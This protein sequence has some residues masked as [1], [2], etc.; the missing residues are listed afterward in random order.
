VA[1]AT[2]QKTNTVFIPPGE[3]KQVFAPAPLAWVIENLEL[4]PDGILS[5]V[6][7]PSILRIKP[8]IYVTADG[9]AFEDVSI[10]VNDL[11]TPWMDKVPD[12]GFKTG[13]PKAVFS[14]ELLN[15]GARMLLYRIGSRLYSFSGGHDSPDQVLLSNLSTQV[16]P[17]T[18]DQFVVI[19]DQIVY[20][21]GVDRPQ[22]IT[23]DN[24][25]TPLGYSRKAA[26]P[27]VSSPSQPSADDAVNYYPN[28]KGYSWQGRIGTAGDEL[29]GQAAALLKGSWF[30]YF[31]YEDINGNLSEI[32]VPSEAATV[33]TNQAEPFRGISLEPVAYDDD[34][35]RPLQKL[36]SGGKTTGPHTLPEGTEIDDL[37]RRFLVRS[38]GDLPEHTVATRIFRTPDTLHS[39]AIPRF[40]VRVPGSRQFFYD[41][42]AADVELGFEWTETI[43]VP[44]FRVACAHQ[45]RLI[46]GNIPGSSGVVRRSEVGFPGTF[47]LED[48]IFPDGDGD[49]IT[50]LASHNGNLIAF[51]K[52]ST[53]VIDDD[54]MSPKP[55][56]T[57]VG[58]IGPRSI[59]ATPDGSLIWLSRDGFYALGAN[60]ALMKI[61]TSIDKTF[62]MELNRSQ[63]KNAVSV[64]DPKSKEYR[65]CLALKGSVE[66][67]IM[68][69]FD[70]EFWR[71]QTLGIH[72]ADLCVVKDFTRHIVAVGSDPREQ[73]IVVAGPGT[74]SSGT[75]VNFRNR[76]DLA[77]I[78]VLDRQSTDYFGPSRRVRY[79]SSWLRSGDFGLVPTNVRNL[80]VGML[81]SWVGTA[82][83]RL[84]RN[85]SWEPFTEMNDLLL[86][87]PDDGS[88]IVSD[89]AREA[90]VGKART[91]ESR[92]FWRQIPVGIE[93]ANSWAFEIEFVGGVS[94]TP[95][96]PDEPKIAPDVNFFDRS[97]QVWE[98]LYRDNDVGAEEFNKAVKIPGTW[99]LGRLKLFGFAFDVSIAT[100]G[101]PLGRVPY[102]QDR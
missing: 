74:D 26:A 92:V 36:I 72:V 58:C 3:G 83:V 93:N 11:T 95:P 67:R 59:Q 44:L 81:D 79:R 14:A 96:D 75:T 17:E 63:F 9:S 33:H 45:G 54:F 89:Q 98:S 1:G 23:S 56:S 38:P 101:T 68:L 35:E 10:D 42:N 85:G 47:P 40:L 6:V 51:T 62:K 82:T 91:R 49:A 87:G 100:Q 4:G 71:R 55:I 41:D 19:N 25:A 53:Y 46:I 97:K 66:N 30:Y 18:L 102:R 32:S 84:Y 86:C 90:V 12:Y 80:Y 52:N 78:F 99:E 76:V 28:S 69:C 88:G 48:F 94:P 37:T 64:L 61:S 8:E 20:F 15:G 60:N 43:S 31:Q 50:G 22:V 57:G 5:S 34:D 2:E 27:G 39:D 13:V 70:G 73:N 24:S 65:C 77:R 21:N 16:N 7:G 29:T